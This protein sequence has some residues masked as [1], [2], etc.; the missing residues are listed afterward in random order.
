MHRRDTARRHAAAAADERPQ[1]QDARSRGLQRPTRPPGLRKSVEACEIP[2]SSSKY[3]AVAGADLSLIV[4]M[5]LAKSARACEA[6]FSGTASP[7]GATSRTGTVQFAKAQWRRGF[8]V[9]KWSK[10]PRS[11]GGRTKLAHRP[12]TPHA[13]NL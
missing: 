6:V 4:V 12:K 7:R 3:C 11:N 5:T 1:P 8:L 2:F 10:K 9:R 13:P